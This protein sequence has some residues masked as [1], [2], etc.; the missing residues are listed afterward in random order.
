MT[1]E[2]RLELEKKLDEW[3]KERNVALRPIALAPRGGWVDVLNYTPDSW[4]LKFI[5]VGMN[6]N[7][8]PQ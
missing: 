1:E 2:Q 4:P 7:G 8:L 5:L 6:N 3:L